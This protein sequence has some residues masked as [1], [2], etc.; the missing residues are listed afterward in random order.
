[1]ARFD[2]RLRE[3]RDLFAALLQREDSLERDWQRLFTDHPIILSESLPLRLKPSQIIACGRPGK[4][5]ADLLFYPEDTHAVPLV[6]GVVELKRPS[7]SILSEPRQHVLKLSSDASTALAQGRYYAAQMQREL[8]DSTG[9]VLAVGGGAHIFLIVGNSAELLA[10]VTSEAAR[11]QF[12]ELLPRGCQLLPYDT[13]LRMFEKRVPPRIHV[14]VPTPRNDRAWRQQG[15]STQAPVFISYC[16]PH[17]SFVARLVRA[18]R[19]SRINVFD[20]STCEA[21]AAHVQAVATEIIKSTP[22]AIMILSRESSWKQSVSWDFGQIMQ[23]Q[24]V[25]GHDILI[26]VALDD[27]WRANPLASILREYRVLDFAGWEDEQKFER[28]LL[29]LM[30][31][32]RT[33]A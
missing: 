26:A 8:H 32:L 13:L 14:A 17:N 20:D 28:H 7:T 29:L 19:A 25:L 4:S 6:Y 22:A 10:R 5:E 9:H 12:D 24:R 27:S 11:Q 30:D 3:A 21:E 31:A 2:R 15:V 1:M 33:A 23:R 16:S 18:L